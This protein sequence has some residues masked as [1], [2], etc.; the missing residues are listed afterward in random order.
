MNFD[1]NIE[2]YT[3]DELIQMFELPSNFDR[4]IIDIKESKLREGII[5]NTEINKDTQIK[6]LNFLLKAKNII[7]NKPNTPLQ[8][9]IEDFYNS[10]Y[11]LKSTELEDKDEH[12]VQV[13]QEKPYLSSFPSEF[14]PGVINPL[15]KR[16]IK[17]NLNIDTRFRENYYSSTSSNFNL[18]LPMNINN[19]VQMQ[20][21]AIE[22]PTTFYVVSKQY[23]N[24]F[25]SLSV[26][27][28][29]T[30]VTIPTGNYDQTTIM[31]AINN[32]LSLL[33]AP[34]NLVAFVLNLTNG[35]TGSGQVLVGEI[36]AGTITSLEID[37]QTDKNGID[38]RG[39]P[40]PLKL[41][42]LL[43]F[44][45]GNYVNNLNYVS[46]GILDISGPSYIYLVLDDYHNNVNNNFFSAF[47]S[48]ILNKNILARI[49]LQAN[50]FNVLQQN[51]LNIITTPREY[52]GPINLQIMNIQLLDEYG[53]ILDLNNM[54]F[55]F[56]ITLTTVYDL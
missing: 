15:K 24:N 18:N 51:N 26:N 44:R 5:N 19:I 1:L 42:W 6:T 49:S 50:P 48:S 7:L 30:T 3:R 8:K 47:N 33:G 43:G 13:R 39:T 41:G 56:C 21:S 23:G 16:T 28:S 25:F 54:D 10:S 52:F 35:T 2:N 11:E 29:T 37:F 32:Q 9:K 12:M 14:F 27:G 40:L 17:K 55:S 22:L 36:T 38:D 45:N 4:N 20:L 46:E 34:F 31:V 53:R